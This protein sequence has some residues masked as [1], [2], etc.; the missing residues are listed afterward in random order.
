MYG[1]TVIGQDV[2]KPSFE[3]LSELL[4]QLDLGIYSPPVPAPEE[5]LRMMEAAVAKKALKSPWL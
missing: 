3:H 2:W 4:E 5:A 1:I